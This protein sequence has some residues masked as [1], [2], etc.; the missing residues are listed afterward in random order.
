VLRKSFLI[1]LAGLSSAHAC[2]LQVEKAWIRSSPPGAMM[3]AGYATLTNKG[4]QPI[5]LTAVRSSAFKSIEMHESTI[6]DGVAKMRELPSVVVPAKAEIAFVPGGRH[7]MLM[8]AQGALPVGKRVVLEL[9]AGPDCT[10]QSEFE[11]RAAAP[12]PLSHSEQ[13]NH[14]D[15]HSHPQD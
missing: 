12:S 1:W 7:L 15:Q 9:N 14:G 6:E 13:H 11:V 5:T 4:A 10:V 3:M 8:G 2:E